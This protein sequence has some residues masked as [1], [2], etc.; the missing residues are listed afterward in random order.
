MT[1][2]EALDKIK[3]D[4]FPLIVAT[5]PPIPTTMNGY[6]KEELFELI[7]KELKALDVL[8]KSKGGEMRMIDNKGNTIT[9]I[10]I[11]FNIKSQQEYDLLKE[12]LL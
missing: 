3:N 6:T 12:V 8:R 10:T 2:I 11:Q 7:E 1:G 4:D 9:D 5:Y